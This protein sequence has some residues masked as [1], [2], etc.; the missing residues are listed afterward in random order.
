MVE[1]VAPF[2]PEQATPPAT[3]TVKSNGQTPPSDESTGQPTAKRKGRFANFK[4]DVV[5]PEGWVPKEPET[6]YATGFGPP[7][8]DK[9]FRVDPDPDRTHVL[10]F[11]KGKMPGSD[12]MIDTLFYVEDTARHLPEIAE[13]VQ[14]YAVH[15]VVNS[16]GQRSVWARRLPHP[17]RKDTWATTDA[18]IAKAAMVQWVRR[19]EDTTLESGG[20]KAVT[21]PKDEEPIPKPVWTDTPF[22][23]LLEK[24]IPEEHTISSDRHPL[25]IFLRTGKV[26]KFTSDNDH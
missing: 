15:V 8:S 18:S 21:Q 3:E 22:E 11:Y 17:S 25:I 6:T 10:M 9:W 14:P 20:W 19:V 4:K 12:G 13:K 16:F 1:H 23:E 2:Q 24:A 7:R 5:G 26:V